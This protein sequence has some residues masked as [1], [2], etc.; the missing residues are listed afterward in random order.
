MK[1]VS[2]S[3]NSGALQASWGRLLAFSSV[4]ESVGSDT[5]HGWVWGVALAVDECVIQSKR[6]VL[7]M[8]LDMDIDLRIYITN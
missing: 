4:A 2:L 6:N 1:L 3:G 8:F 7:N 5:S